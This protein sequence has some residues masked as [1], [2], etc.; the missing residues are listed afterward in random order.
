M[1]NEQLAVVIFNTIK[2]LIVNPLK[3]PYHPLYGV[4]NPKYNSLC[5]LT[6]NFCKKKKAST[7]F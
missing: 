6:S 5:F 1:D 3:G 7:S 4:T 2:K